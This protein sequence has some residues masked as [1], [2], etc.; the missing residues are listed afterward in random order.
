MGRKYKPNLRGK[1]YVKHTREAINSALADHRRGMSFRPCSRKQGISIAV[2]CRR[3]CNP[4]IKTQGGQTALSK[5]IL[6]NLWPAELLLA[7]LGV[8][9][10]V[11]LMYDIS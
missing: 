8:F 9:H 11:I 4:R 2:L 10:W 3:A 1:K 5:D 6:R 7:Q